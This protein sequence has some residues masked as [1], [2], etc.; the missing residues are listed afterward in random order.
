MLKWIESGKKLADVPELTYSFLYPGYLQILP[1][2]NFSVI[3]RGTAERFNV[4]YGGYFE[5]HK[6]S[7]DEIYLLGFA[8]EETYANISSE[9]TKVIT[10]FPYPNVNRNYLLVILVQEIIESEDREITLDDGSRVTILDL[11]LD[12]KK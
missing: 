4:F 12:S 8:S 7:N 1:Y 6:I 9:N 5:V 11:S 3:L 2:E 10:L